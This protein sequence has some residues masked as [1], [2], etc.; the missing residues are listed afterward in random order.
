MRHRWLWAVAGLVSLAIG[1]FDVTNERPL[2]PTLWPATAAA[3][4]IALSAGAVYVS[5]RVI[6]AALSTAQ[7]VEIGASIGAQAN[8]QPLKFLE[9][10]DD[11]VERVAGVVFVIAAGAALAGLG[12]AP[13]AGLGLC[14]LGIGC[15]I[16]AAGEGR[17]RLAGIEGAGAYAMR[18]GAVFGLGLPVI[19]A[20]GVGLGD[21]LTASRWDR[22]MS[23]L[24]GVTEEARVLV[25][26][27]VDAELAAS[28][29]DPGVFAEDAQ[30]EAGGGWFDWIGS[31]VQ[32]VGEGFGGA[33]EATRRY[34]RAGGLLM[35]RADDVFSA[36]LTI[37]G[38]FVLRTLVL[39]GLLLW[40]LVGLMRRVVAAG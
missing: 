1:V 14:L 33:V 10:L 20:L 36:S 11:T 13:V 17:P 2:N 32:S 39:P 12:L 16:R 24:A 4:D 6:N 5:L 15:L 30:T 9:P 23:D 38:V 22:A 34:I 35:S 25:G 37:I 26:A 7:E 18:M 40:A 28:G 3:E 21:A 27:V 29:V 31:G 19:F 8:L